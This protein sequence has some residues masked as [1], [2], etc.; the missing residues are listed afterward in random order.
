VVSFSFDPSHVVNFLRA[1]AR[2][3]VGLITSKSGN[4]N[5]GVESRTPTANHFHVWVINI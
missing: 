4:K 2:Q 3:E 1:R 5:P